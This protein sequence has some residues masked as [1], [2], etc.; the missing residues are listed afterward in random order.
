MDGIGSKL[1]KM[2]AINYNSLEKQ[3]DVCKDI[4]DNIHYS[5]KRIEQADSWNQT[6]IA[7]WLYSE[8]KR[9]WR[10]QKQIKANEWWQRKFIRELTKLMEMVG[11]DLFWSP[12]NV[13]SFAKFYT[14]HQPNCSTIEDKLQLFTHL[15]NHK[16]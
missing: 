8:D 9:K 7:K 5:H 6:D 1:T 3:L 13:K 14:K 15:K 2:K 11:M 10:V 4:L 12:E 16:S